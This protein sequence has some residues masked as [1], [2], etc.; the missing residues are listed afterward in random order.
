VKY[1]KKTKILA[2]KLPGMQP[3]LLAVRRVSIY[4]PITL[5]NDQPERND[6]PMRGLTSSIQREPQ[7]SR[8]SPYRHCQKELFWICWLGKKR[9]VKAQETKGVDLQHE[10]RDEQKEQVV[11]GCTN[12]A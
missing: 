10:D 4:Q 5:K 2:A 11:A 9:F 3:L 12:P 7:L 8:T 1:N 6:S